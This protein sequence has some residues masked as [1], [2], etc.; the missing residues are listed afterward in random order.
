MR[1]ITRTAGQHSDQDEKH[2]HRQPEPCGELAREDPD[3]QQHTADQQDLI[4]AK[5]TVPSY[6]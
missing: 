6:I 2:Q 1:L 5:H 3:E 4:D